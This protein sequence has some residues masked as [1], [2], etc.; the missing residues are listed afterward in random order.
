MLGMRWSVVHGLNSFP[1]FL[2]LE[3]LLTLGAFRIDSIA[4][5]WSISMLLLPSMHA[6]VLRLMGLS[7]AVLSCS[8]VA[9]SSVL[10]CSGDLTRVTQ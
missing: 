2:A 3:V 9:T 5:A 1:S 10:P 6:V 4:H 7:W 8:T